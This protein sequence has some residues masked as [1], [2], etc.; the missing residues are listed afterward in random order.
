MYNGAFLKV[1]NFTEKGSHRKCF[2]LNFSISFIAHIFVDPMNL[3]DLIRIK[4]K[5]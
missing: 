3:H 5:I 4:V 1:V 2:L